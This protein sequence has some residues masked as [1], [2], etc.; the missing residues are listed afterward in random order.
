M[1]RQTVQPENQSLKQQTMTIQQALDLGV[2]HHSAGQLAE[3]ES[4]YQKILQAEPNQPV[5]LNLLGVIA[6]QTGKYDIAVNL[7]TRALAINP[8]FAEAHNNLGLVYKEQAKLDEAVASYHQALTINP[9]LAEA[10]NNLGLVFKELGKLEEAVTTYQRV[11]DIK[12]DFAEVHNNLG[13]LLLDLGQLDEAIASFRTALTIKPDYAVAAYNQGNVFRDMG[14]FEESVLSY[15]KALA[16][17]SDLSEAHGNL[18]L[19]YQELGALDEALASYHNSLAIKPDQPEVFNNLGTLFKK[20]GKLNEAIEYYQKAIA[21][22]ANSR[23]AISN[24]ST[25]KTKCVED[26][27]FNLGSLDQA[28]SQDVN[29]LISKDVT[30]DSLKVNL[31]YCPF[32][33]PITPPLG[34]A[35]L[36]AYLEKYNNVQVSCMDLNL[37]WHTMMAENGQSGME[38]LGKAETLFKND[39]TFFDLA[40][41]TGVAA[42]LAECLDSAHT[43]TQYSMCQ[44]NHS[45]QNN[46]VSYLKTKA[47]SGNPDVVGLSVLF[48]SQI[49]C[50]LLVAKKIK[51]ENPEVIVV[52]GGAGMLSSGDQ[53]IQ[54]PF[55]DFVVFDSGEASFSLLLNCIR[56]G[57]LN[58]AIPGVAFKKDG[59]VIKNKAIP[60]NLN[61]EAYPDFSDFNLDGYFTNEVV[62]PILSSKGCVWRLCSFCE[63]GSIN[64]FSTALVDRVVDEIEFHSSNG[65]QYFQ[66]VDEMIAPERL[67]LISKEIISRK[68]TVFFYATLRPSA[69]FDEET[70]HLMYEAGFRYVIWGVE[71]FNK[72]LLK[73]VRK[74]TSVKSIRNT[75]NFSKNVGIRNHIF[76]MVGFPSE[77]PDE[78]FETMQ[79]IYDHSNIIHQ[80]HIGRFGLC[81]GTE[82]F[83]NP[84]KFGIEIEFSEHN[85]HEFTVKH[86]NG[87]TGKNSQEYFQYYMETFLKKIGVSYA[88]CQLRDPALLHYVKTPLAEHEMVRKKIPQ[89]VLMRSA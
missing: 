76:M 12:P 78:L 42:D 13:L 19:V 9:E 75:L 47:M 89:P 56:D 15:L 61:H 2:Q 80:I 71:S 7:I 88:F 4:I 72:R 68:L 27:I 84:D 20:M 60:G 55:V 22:G 70:L 45:Q 29:T 1:S 38:P 18:G 25:A 59:E 81:E 41:Y 14:K 62:I 8:E 3:A 77:T 35:S 48:N 66:F 17:N 39:D 85:Q 87:T 46:I 52:F 83:L 23:W 37:E 69:D 49:L 54:N 34:I 5:A 31:L 63:E 67:R 40:Q 82:I 11:I 21:L 24:L 16:I 53:I 43:N 57:K 58:E 64:L 86:K 74:G 26:Y 44:D 50:S 65:H 79:F 30:Y 10:H 73:L 36:K 32:F 6:H 28:D 51:Q 33:D